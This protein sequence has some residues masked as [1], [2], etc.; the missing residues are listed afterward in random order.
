VNRDYRIA[1]KRERPDISANTLIVPPLLDVLG[2]AP[3]GTRPPALGTE[4]VVVAG[5]EET[6]TV[7]MVAEV[8]RGISVVVVAGTEP[9]AAGRTVV[10]LLPA[11]RVIGGNSNPFCAHPA[12]SSVSCDNRLKST[13]L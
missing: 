2:E 8:V 12:S 3:L 5:T 7:G 11:I 10:V 1:Y 6:T 9:V 13:I 4:A